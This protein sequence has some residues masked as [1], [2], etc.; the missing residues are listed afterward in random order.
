[1]RSTHVG[2]VAASNDF[3]FGVDE[4]LVAPLSGTFQVCFS[5]CGAPHAT[6]VGLMTLVE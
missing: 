2:H 3:G 6:C 1:M 4:A 5:L